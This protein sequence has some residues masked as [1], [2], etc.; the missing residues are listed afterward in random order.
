VAVSP[1]D[2]VVHLSLGS[3]A[4]S[5]SSEIS[6]LHVLLNLVLGLQ[7]SPRFHVSVT[8]V[9][10]ELVFTYTWSRFLLSLS[11]QLF[12]VTAL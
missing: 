4:L 8:F 2:S 6:E 7:S 1:G 12:S 5:L 9:D 11:N 10:L 3:P